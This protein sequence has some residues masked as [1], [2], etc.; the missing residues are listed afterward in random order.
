MRGV[1]IAVWNFFDPFYYACTRLTFPIKEK[2]ENI[3]R[4]RLTIYKGRNVVLSDGTSI[5]KN[6]MLVKI[7]LH[8]V[9]LLK[10]LKNIKSDFKK[11]AI[12]YR[13]VKHSLPDIHCY[14][15]NHAHSGKIKGI[16]GISMLYKGSE[17]LGFDV[18][19]IANPFYKA[20]KQIAH[21]PISFLANTEYSMKERL[22]QQ[23]KYLIM[24]KEMLAKKYG[25]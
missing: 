17:H 3:F 18:F 4:I 5:N 19:E 8:N 1:I 10:E 14:I 22:C 20:F 13:H 2:K 9:K 6:D 15:T 16:I 24:S 25:A 11:A 12:L 7:H 21:F 23:P